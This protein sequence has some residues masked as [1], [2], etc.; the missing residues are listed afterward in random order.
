LAKP[1]TARLKFRQILLI[2]A[3]FAYLYGYYSAPQAT[4]AYSVMILR[5]LINLL[6]VLLMA[7]MQFVAIF[8][9]MGRARVYW[10]KAGETQVSFKDYKGNDEVLE[11]ASRIVTLL[12]GV[13][14][15]KDMGG[16]VS[17][18]LLLVGPPGTGKSYLAMAIATEANLPFAYA[19]APSFQ[20]MFFGVGNLRVMMLYKKAR[21]L[22]LEHGAAIIFIDE[23]DAIGLSRGARGGFGGGVQ[24]MFGAGLGLLNELLLQMDPPNMEY[25][26]WAK[27]LRRF[28]FRP[29]PGPQ[30]IVLT[31]GAT[32]LPE[33][34][35]PALLR[36]GRFDRQLVVDVPDFEGR[37]EVIEYYLNKVRHS[38]SISIDRLSSD[39][40]GYSPVKIKH[41]INEAVIRAHFEGRTAITYDD[42]TYAREVHEWGLKQPIKSMTSEERKRI[43]YH[44]AGHAVAQ[45]LLK[46]NERVVKTTIIRHGRALGLS[47]TKPVVETYTQTAAEILAEIQVDLGARAAEELFLNCKTNGAAMDLQ[48]ATSLA[49][50]Y[51]GLY[52][53][54]GTLYSY[55]AMGDRTPSPELRRRINQLLNDQ[56][57]QVAA[58]LEDHA[59]LVHALAQELIVRYEVTGD[60]LIAMAEKYSPKSGNR[61]PPVILETEYPEVEVAASLEESL[62]D[63]RLQEE[64]L[65]VF[66]EPGPGRGEGEDGEERGPGSAG[67]IPG[68]LT[69]SAGRDGEIWLY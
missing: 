7:V 36:P 62:E 10:I 4:F 30:P 16:Q 49:S 3:V 38:P 29:R 8:W 18:G 32:N 39:M 53:M 58:L 13:K 25:R 65:V 26:M 44:E 63:R 20:N 45:L 64:N 59:D 54:G 2:A 69:A 33:A 67:R 19:S 22:A 6:F 12:R 14:K 9:F 15:F 61:R 42:I 50:A 1:V 21:K 17:K 56:K 40:I 51:I 35:D 68:F 46:P 47:A 28:G 52:G 34:L 43:A 24:T 11:A 41:V 57:R 60:E 31:I 23:L 27:I 37:K 5:A 55:A 66:P 48:Q